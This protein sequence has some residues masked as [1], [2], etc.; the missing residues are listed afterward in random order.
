MYQAYQALSLYG[1]VKGKRVAK[2]ST[3]LTSGAEAPWLACDL[4]GAMAQF[5]Q[6][7]KTG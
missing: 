5:C 4:T 3:H 2:A 1:M 6:G 7:D